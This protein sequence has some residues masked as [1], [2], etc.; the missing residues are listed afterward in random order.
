MGSFQVHLSF[1]MQICIRNTI[2]SGTCL[3]LQKRHGLHSIDL[4]PFNVLRLLYGTVAYKGF[5]SR[6]SR[7]W[8]SKLSMGWRRAVVL[9]RCLW[10]LIVGRVNK[11][12]PAQTYCCESSL[13][14]ALSGFV[15]LCLALS[16]PV[17]LFW[18][19]SGPIGLCGS[20]S[21]PVRLCWAL[22]SLVGLCWALSGSVGP[23]WALSGPGKWP[24]IHTLHWDS[25]QFV[26]KHLLGW[27]KRR[28]KFLEGLGWF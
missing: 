26:L 3:P 28:R 4:E 17:R 14:R 22:S 27:Y 10:V 2:Q 7:W 6:W 23:C 12:T 15:E 20:V 1:K 9:P 21:S 18:A 5:C 16:G 8:S 24:H 13:S 25:S 19:R 11:F